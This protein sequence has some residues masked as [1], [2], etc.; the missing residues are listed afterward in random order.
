MDGLRRYTIFGIIF[1]LLMGTLA[2]FVYD[3]TGRSH[4]VGYFVPVNESVWEH[5]KLVFFP[6]LLYA[7]FIIA[8]CKNN[9]QC[10]ISSLCAGILSGT[11]FIPILFYAYTSILGKN[12]LILDIGVFI[13]STLVAFWVF[14]R[15]EISCNRKSVYKLFFCGLTA[16]LFICFMAFTYHPP[17]N[18]IFEDPTVSQKSE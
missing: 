4:I 12:Y 5:M 9:C 18:T 13:I 17:Q 16:V 14:Y 8:K 11:A 10:I 2:H 6:M 15:L 7:V 3:W 1:V